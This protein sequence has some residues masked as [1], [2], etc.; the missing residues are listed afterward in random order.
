M[1]NGKKTDIARA[2]R[3]ERRQQVYMLRRNGASFR[4]IARQLDI[5]HDTA[6]KD[7]Q[8]VM[9]RVIEENNGTAQEHRELDLARIDRLIQSLAPLL[10]PT[11]KPGEQAKPPD[12]KALDRY[13]RAL[14]HRAKLLG[15]YAPQQLDTT[16]R[17][18]DMDSVKAELRRKIEAGEMTREQAL[19]VTDNDTDLVNEFFK[20]AASRVSVGKEN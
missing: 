15:L 8:A 7:F 13:L 12:L 18:I 5:T 20:G 6:H 2:D 1:A 17:V 14:D 10:Y 4:D 11:V 19:Q 9:K 3:E 16:V